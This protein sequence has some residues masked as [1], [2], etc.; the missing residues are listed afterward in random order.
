MKF[1]NSTLASPGG[2]VAMSPGKSLGKWEVKDCKNFRALSICKK[3]SKPLEPEEAAPKPDGPCPEGWHTFPSSFSCYKVKYQ[4]VQS[5]SG[6]LFVPSWLMC[7]Y[8]VY[9]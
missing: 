5:F 1:S 7:L 4:R 3:I 9:S 2:C 8:K 6:G